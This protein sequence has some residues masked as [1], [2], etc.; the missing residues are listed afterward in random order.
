MIVQYS[1]IIET[2]GVKLINIYIDDSGS[3]SLKDLDQPVYLLSAV[4][5]DNTYF[6]DVSDKMNTIISRLKEKI[7][8]TMY[9][10]FEK[11]SYTFGR[12]NK[13]SHLLTEMVIS[14]EFELHCSEIIRGDIPYIILDKDDRINTIKRVL[15]I[16]DKLNI[17]IFTVYCDKH[18]FTCRHGKSS[19]SDTLLNKRMNEALMESLFHYLEKNDEYACI[20]A[21]EGNYTVENFT[22][23]YV[24]EHPNNRISSEIM[25][26]KS[27]ESVNIQIADVCAYTSNMK[28]MHN[29][30]KD[31]YK[32]KKI[33][34][35]LFAIIEPYNIIERIL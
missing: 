21:D 27:Y 29:I 3:R 18:E 12:S 17:Q 8:A 7:E 23:P 20:I 28:L 19:E 13:L 16:I 22:V 35:E 24:I 31:N 26:K 10:A 30:K 32:H 34:E 6:N 33:A 25:Q 9:S 15:R 2:G 1:Q 11:N 4:C 5:I 14:E